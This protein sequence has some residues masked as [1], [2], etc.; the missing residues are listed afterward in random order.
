M[1]MRNF[2]YWLIA[3][4]ILA[5]GYFAYEHFSTPT[6]T[7]NVNTS[8]NTT[9]TDNS[10]SDTN[11]ASNSTNNSAS[12]QDT[13]KD[14]TPIAS[15]T[16]NMKGQRVKIT[17][18]VSDI[19]GGKGHTF[20]IFKDPNTSDNIKVVLFKQDN[21]QDP[22]RRQQ[23]EASYNSKSVINIEGKVDVYEGELEVIAKK[24]Y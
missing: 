23:I 5:G 22:T 24:V 21:E 7:N 19:S 2:I 12:K 20:F 4:V 13:I 10:S 1:C 6:P 17:G 8:S 14:F 18:Y 15:I 3:I 11:T 9:S 16:E